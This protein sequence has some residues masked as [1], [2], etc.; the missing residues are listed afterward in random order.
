MLVYRENPLNYG[1]VINKRPTCEMRHSAL[2]IYVN[3][4]TGGRSGSFSVVACLVCLLSRTVVI[5]T[6]DG[7]EFPG[8]LRIYG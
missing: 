5:E 3:T 6:C 8:M 2:C 4:V 7:G 1:R